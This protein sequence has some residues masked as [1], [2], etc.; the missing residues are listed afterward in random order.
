[1]KSADE[2]PH[3][4]VVDDNVDA[5][6]VLALLIESDGFTASTAPSLA[7]A[8]REIASRHPEIVLLDLHLPDGPGLS[9]LAE[10]KASQHTAPT[11]VIVVSGMLEQ[12]VREEAHLLGAAA[13]LVKPFEHDQ[14]SR[15]LHAAQA[16]R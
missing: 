14:L 6:E 16:A 4:L 8:R 13:F 9:L 15:A 10:I 1:M 5:A 2:F 12:A 3:V 7:A 11:Q